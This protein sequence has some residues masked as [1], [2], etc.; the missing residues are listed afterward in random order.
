MKNNLS[1]LIC[2]SLLV[3]ML[4]CTPHPPA[5]RIEPKNIPAEKEEAR[6]VVPAPEKPVGK[7]PSN[8]KEVPARP[9]QAKPGQSPKKGVM[10]GYSYT[11]VD[12]ASMGNEIVLTRD[13]LLV[14]EEAEAPAA[15]EEVV[16]E[17]EDGVLKRHKIIAGYRIQAYATTN[18]KDAEKKKEDLVSVIEDPVYVIY[19][20]PYYKIRVGNF[21]NEDE[22]KELRKTLEEMGHDASVVQSKIRVRIEEGPAAKQKKK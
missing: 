12:S 20:P 16:T 18:F 6:I 3:L 17:G 21:K 11:V 19:E 14:E 4:D 8:V 10:G 2:S 5:E 9:E 1:I 7:P 22:A 13:K 15:N